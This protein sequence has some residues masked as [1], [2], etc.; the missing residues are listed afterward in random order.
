MAL[1][2]LPRQIYKQN[3]ALEPRILKEIGAVHRMFVTPFPLTESDKANGIQM[4]ALQ[5][6]E[7]SNGGWLRPIRKSQ[8]KEIYYRS[9]DRSVLK[10][11]MKDLF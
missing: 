11:I 9:V 5:E 1:S 2:E 6:Y 3:S 4:A 8:V 10:E 7:A